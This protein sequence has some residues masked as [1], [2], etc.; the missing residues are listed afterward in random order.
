M[1]TGKE[2]VTATLQE[3]LISAIRTAMGG[4][5]PHALHEPVFTGNEWYYLKECLDSTYVSSVGEFVDRFESMLAEYTGARRAVAVVNGTAALHIAL[6][7]AGVKEGDEVICP[8]FTFVATANAVSYCGGTPHFADIEEKTLG[9]DPNK[10]SDYLSEIAGK[11]ANGYYNKKTGRRLRAVVP[12]HT[13]GHP[14]DMDPLADACRRY[15]L[16]LIE[17][18]AESLGT[19]YKDRHAGRHG[20]MATLS[21]NGNKIITTGGGGAIL[22]NDDALANRAK[23][24]TTTAKLPNGY[25]FFH[26]EVGYNYRLPNLNA[27]L[28]CAQME[29]LPRLLEQKRRL[30][31]SYKKVFDEVEGVRF[32][33]EPHFA[34]SNYWLNV[35]LLDAEYAPSLEAAIRATNEAG[36]MTRPAWTPMHK[37][38]M[39]RDCPRM[40]LSVTEDIEK[41][42]ICLPSR[43]RLP[44][45]LGGD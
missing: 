43:P 21:F 45:E 19:L 10:L 42:L 38:P 17:D 40:D 37:L 28:G 33:T 39:Y 15:G 29:T 12:V 9:L 2:T 32:F 20:A 27:A 5:G 25:A 18:A 36:F 24:I 23:H 6:R 35:A 1:S 31:E 7:L 22:T 14:V 16:Q 26:D 4:E 44:N 30:A 41:R 8:S 11:D 3:R 13:Y 34:R